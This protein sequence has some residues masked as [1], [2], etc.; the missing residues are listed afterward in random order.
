MSLVIGIGTRSGADFNALEEVL[1]GMPGIAALATIE[2]RAA[3][4][5][6][7]ARRLGLPLLAIPAG[8]LA[9]VA[10][11][12]ASARIMAL[13]RCGSVAEACALVAAGP[14]SVIVRTR[15]A[16]G[17]TTWAAARKANT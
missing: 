1:H 6:P 14:G 15:L 16:L 12:S 5:E 4:L 11:P 8:D 10:T 3:Q 9:G 2:I 13:H 7:L 17:G